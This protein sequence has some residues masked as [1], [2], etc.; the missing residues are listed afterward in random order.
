M[1]T[2]EGGGNKAVFYIQILNRAT[3]VTS[4]TFYDKG[5]I[6]SLLFSLKLTP[7]S[8]FQKRYTPNRLFNFQILLQ[9]L[10]SK[11]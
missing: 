4:A 10:I 6:A 8:R 2:E 7:G 5:E 11:G 3:F 1:S 9:V